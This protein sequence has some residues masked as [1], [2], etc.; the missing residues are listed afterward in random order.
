MALLMSDQTSDA[1][2]QLAENFLRGQITALEAERARVE[3][4]RVRIDAERARIDVELAR[5]KSTLAEMTRLG[6]AMPSSDAPT[7]SAPREQEPF[8]AE[9][10][11]TGAFGRLELTDAIYEYLL[12]HKQMKSIKDIWAALEKAGVKVLSG[13]PTRA[14]NEAL[15]RRAHR[16]N[17]VFKAA[18]RWGATK[19]FSTAYIRRVIKLHGGMG[20]RSAEEHSAAT[21]AGMERRRAS[22]LRIGAPRKFDA[23]MAVEIKRLRAEGVTIVDTCKRVGISVALYQQHRKRL[24][25]W[26]EGTAWPPPEPSE[27]DL[28]LHKL[29]EA[30]STRL[31]IVK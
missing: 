9:M 29:Q 11:K 24:M 30:Q 22:G 12:M 4:E 16:Q 10:P 17:D 20:G 31:R 6:A 26:K 5:T 23:A 15:R 2:L 8:E 28:A 21:S 3:A 7:S 18:N 19:N 13:H 14:V 1:A 25:V 27:E